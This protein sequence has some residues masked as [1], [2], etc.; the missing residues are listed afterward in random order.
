VSKKTAS[1]L[2][3]LEQLPNSAWDSAR[4]GEIFGVCKGV[5]FLFFIAGGPDKHKRSLIDPWIDRWLL[6][7]CCA[8]SVATPEQAVSFVKSKTG[9]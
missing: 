2:N 9:G 5:P 8:W 3:S 6:S 1:F 4:S 7:G